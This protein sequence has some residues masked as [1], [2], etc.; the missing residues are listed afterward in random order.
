MS[1]PFRLTSVLKAVTS[2]LTVD[3]EFSTSQMRDLV[4][5][6]RNIHSDDVTFLTA[7]FAGYDT[8]P[9][10]QSVVLLKTK[11]HTPSGGRSRTT[12][13]SPTSTS[14]VATRC[15]ARTTWN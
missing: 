15:R 13:S 7:P 2:N 3:Q 6:L 5:S 4:L 10:G 8:T 14:T 12:T 9:D 1:N 11:G